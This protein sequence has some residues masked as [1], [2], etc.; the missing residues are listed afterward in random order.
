MRATLLRRKNNIEQTLKI[1]RTLNVC[2]EKIHRHRLVGKKFVKKCV[3]DCNLRCHDGH[4][5]VCQMAHSDEH[6][7]ISCPASRIWFETSKS[8]HFMVFGLFFSTVWRPL[9]CVFLTIS[10][11]FAVLY[12][13]RKSFSK[14][15][16]FEQSN[17]LNLNRFC[18]DFLY[19]NST[20]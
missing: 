8:D 19:H 6:V 16:A 5:E 18:F 14:N 15:F 17:K 1:P 10:K 7:P 11:P 20:L 12:V 3:T 9:H 4:S 2:R 13:E